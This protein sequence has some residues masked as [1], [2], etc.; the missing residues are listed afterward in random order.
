V[1]CT[2][3]GQANQTGSFCTACGKSLAALPPQGPTSG[4][5][6]TP[7]AGPTPPPLVSP[8]PTAPP[9]YP[10]QQ[11][12]APPPSKKGLSAGGIVGIVLGSVAVVGLAIFGVVVA[13]TPAEEAPQAQ[14]EQEEE[15]RAS[16]QPQTSGP[17]LGQLWNL[18]RD[19]DFQACDDLY[20]EAPEGSEYR[21]FGDTCGNR[22]EPSGW[23]V[24]LYAENSASSAGY[25]EYGSDSYLDGLWD[26]CSNGDFQAC[27]DLYF[28]APANTGYRDYG[29]SC[30]NR[31]EPSGYCVDIYSGGS[32]TAEAG[33]YG[34]DPVLDYLWDWCSDGDWASCDALWEE[35]PAGSTYEYFGDTCGLRNEPAGWCLDLYG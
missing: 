20:S 6:A 2:H 27:D 8:P 35:A 19:G 7:P 1:F 5:P 30:G 24:E 12:V 23:C 28:A 13:A 21:E 22:N 26:G 9:T 3:C 4:F 10:T 33:E 31:N 32:S 17:S 18:C 15:P 16:I 14:S 29:D 25:G 11:L 34:S